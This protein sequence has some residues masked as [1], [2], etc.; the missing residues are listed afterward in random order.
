M[1]DY[2]SPDYY[3]HI[4]ENGGSKVVELIYYYILLEN[5]IVIYYLKTECAIENLNLI[6]LQKVKDQQL[7]KTF[8]PI[9]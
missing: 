6:N 4:L 7:D 5:Y 9:S 1:F 8:V 2:C 3:S